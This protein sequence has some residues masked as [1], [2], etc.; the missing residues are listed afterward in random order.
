MHSM[1]L[2]RFLKANHS[3]RLMREN[4]RQFALPRGPVFPQF[5]GAARA[6]KDV[7]AQMMAPAGG[8]RLQRVPREA[9]IMDDGRLPEEHPGHRLGRWGETLRRVFGGAPRP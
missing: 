4:D 8:A 3:V 2:V 1:S 9:D 7:L 6:S 5:G